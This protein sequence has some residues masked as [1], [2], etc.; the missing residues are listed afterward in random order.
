[1]GKVL[2]QSI[3]TSLWENVIQ[4]ASMKKD[5]VNVVQRFLDLRDRYKKLG[6]PWK[7]GVIFHGPPGN[8]KT[9]SIKGYDAYAL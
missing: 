1:M 5:L 6:V 8:G 7:R 4:D 9:I 2:W 3:Q